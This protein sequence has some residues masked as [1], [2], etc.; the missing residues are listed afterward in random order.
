M[1][2]SSAGSLS[3]LNPYL[4]RSLTVLCLG[5]Q[6]SVSMS[7]RDALLD[8]QVFPNPMQFDPDR[9]LCATS[10]T[11]KQRMNK[12]YIPFNKGP[13]KCLGFKYVAPINTYRVSLPPF[14]FCAARYSKITS[15]PIFTV[16]LMRTCITAFR[17]WFRALNSRSW[18]RYGAEIST[19]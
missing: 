6:T 2:V 7:P 11:H 18:T 4:E 9:W 12:S 1:Y 19:W 16:W 17:H 5:T 3:T 14:T 10:D 8:P 15:D 13:R